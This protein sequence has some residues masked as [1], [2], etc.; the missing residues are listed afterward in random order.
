[1]VLNFIIQAA[2]QG[3][4]IEKGQNSDQHDKDYD[5]FH[6]GEGGINVPERITQ[7]GFN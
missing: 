1:M 5:F 6:G 7:E 4:H 2:M 3:K